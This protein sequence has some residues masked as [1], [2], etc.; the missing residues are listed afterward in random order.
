M[1]PGLENEVFWCMKVHTSETV[2]PI[3][4]LEI[5]ALCGLMRHI[6]LSHLVPHTPSEMG[7]VKVNIE[8][9]S[10]AAT[11]CVLSLTVMS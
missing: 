8:M 3:Y 7:Y 5:C 2:K 6:C 1:A 11:F 9:N 10:D 4:T